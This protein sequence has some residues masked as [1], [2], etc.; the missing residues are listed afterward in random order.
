MTLTFLT[1][2]DLLQVH[3]LRQAR[4]VEALGGVKSEEGTQ[5]CRP[6]AISPLFKA[7]VLLVVLA[8]RRTEA[9]VILALQSRAEEIGR[10]ASLDLVRE[11]GVHPL[12]HLVYPDT[13]QRSCRAFTRSSAR[14]IPVDVVGLPQGGRQVLRAKL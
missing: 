6:G 11:S 12:V 5:G 14:G 10:V 4:V 3:A 1:L 7:L 2:L 9:D 13:E 8:L